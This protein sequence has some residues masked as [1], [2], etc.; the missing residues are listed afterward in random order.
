MPF[1][2]RAATTRAGAA[3]KTPYTECMREGWR[4]E[5]PAAAGSSRPKISS[6]DGDVAILGFEHGRHK[7]KSREAT[8]DLCTSGLMPKELGRLTKPVK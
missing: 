6:Q 2:T 4:L 5:R 1:L 8:L 3:K 7:I